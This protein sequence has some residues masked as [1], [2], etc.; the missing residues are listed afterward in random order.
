MATHPNGVAAFI[1]K[2]LDFLRSIPIFGQYFSCRAQHHSA[3]LLEFGFVLLSSLLPIGVVSLI[4]YATHDV[5]DFQSW[6]LRF[7]PEM[8]IAASC[9]IAPSMYLFVTPS[10][11]RNDGER[12]DY[13]H[14]GSLQLSCLAVFSLGMILYVLFSCLKFF[15]PTVAEEMKTRI[16]SFAMWVYI[17]ALFLTYT[18]ILFRNFSDNPEPGDPDKDVSPILAQLAER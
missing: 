11:P 6:N 5:T 17:P 18:S 3:A 7:A 9:I 14:K 8:S 12:T 13:P 2:A 16:Y 15:I 1:Q 10:S 4:E